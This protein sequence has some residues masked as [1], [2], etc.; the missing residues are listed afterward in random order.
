MKDVCYIDGMGIVTYSE[1][2][3]TGKKRIFLD[4]IELDKVKKFN[5]SKLINGKLIN[6]TTYGNIL[7]GCKVYIGDHIILVTR[8]PRW[9]EWLLGFLPALFSFILIFFNMDRIASFNA[10]P[11]ICSGL[12]L[13][14]STLISYFGVIYIRSMKKMY[15][16]LVLS[17]GI[18]VLSVLISILIWEIGFYVI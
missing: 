4:D 7:V 18:L 1:N 12:S 16:K 15:L 14:I 6:A 2:I 11:I 8:P 5:Y 10:M 17:L 13:G 9:Y 3:L